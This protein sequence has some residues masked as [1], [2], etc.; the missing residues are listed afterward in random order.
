MDAYLSKPL[1]PGA[2]LRTLDELTAS[3]EGAAATKK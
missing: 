2:L 1:E 3:Q